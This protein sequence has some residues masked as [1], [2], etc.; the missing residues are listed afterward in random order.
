MFPTDEAID[1][2]EI[3]RDARRR[4][5]E[6]GGGPSGVGSGGRREPPMRLG[7]LQ[8]LFLLG[9]VTLLSSLLNRV[10]DGSHPGLTL[11]LMVV[12]ETLLL[13]SLNQV[14]DG[15]RQTQPGLVNE[16]TLWLMMVLG[17]LLS[18]LNQVYDRSQRTQPG[19]VH[20]LRLCPPGLVALVTLLSSTSPLT[21]VCDSGKRTSNQV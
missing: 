3:L 19:L 13:S 2:V 14:Y 15:S 18:S 8:L 20:K 4:R 1:V 17:T 10:Y 12:L 6:Q 9:L 7:P 5:R 21:W 11:W 16:T